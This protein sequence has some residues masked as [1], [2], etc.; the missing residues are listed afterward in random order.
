MTGEQALQLNRA[1]VLIELGRHGD[2]AR[3]LSSLLAADPDSCRGWCL[4]SRAHLGNGE[5]ADAVTAARRASALDP[6]NDWPHRLASTALIGLDRDG[7]AVMAALEARRLGPH[8][9]RSHVCLAQAAAAHGLLELAAEAAQAALA[10]APYQADVHVMAGKVALSRGDV[11]EARVRQEAALAID[12][13]HSG[14]LNEL[15]RISLRSRDAA[16]AAQH[17]LRAARISPGNGVFGRNSELAL[18]RIALRLEGLIMLA[19][20]MLAAIAG[21][22]AAGQWRIAAGLAV[23]EPLLAL[24]ISVRIRAVPPPARGHLLRL[25]LARGRHLGR[26]LNRG[27]DDAHGG[28][29]RGKENPRNPRDGNAAPSAHAARP[30]PGSSGALAG[31]PAQA[32]LPVRSQGRLRLAKAASPR[33]ALAARTAPRSGRLLRLACLRK[34]TLIRRRTPG[35]PAGRHC[36][37]Q[38]GCGDAQ[39][40]SSSR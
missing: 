39:G 8:F 26:S 11:A 14:A 10:L 29:C 20:A 12:P 32:R 7:D 13:A 19:L 36:C 33:L 31:M 2:A 37:R 18:G 4:L 28:V 24:W 23:T 22:T 16:A 38:A 15:G 17:F 40:S 1:S 9:W 25:L 34:A 30:A 35:R 3:L 27:R 6:A 21:L 5:P